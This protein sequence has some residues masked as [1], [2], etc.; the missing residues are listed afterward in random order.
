[1]MTATA[2]TGDWPESQP[3]ELG[4]TL[5]IAPIDGRYLANGMMCGKYFFLRPKWNNRSELEVLFQ[6]AVPVSKEWLT[7]VFAYDY[8]FFVVVGDS[9][10]K[11]LISRVDKLGWWDPLPFHLV[12]HFN[13]EDAKS[14]ERCMPSGIDPRTI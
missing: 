8:N 14:V 9:V 6:L 5:E 7:M 2:L 10:E 3:Y 1:M 13:A 12:V 11:P 4:D